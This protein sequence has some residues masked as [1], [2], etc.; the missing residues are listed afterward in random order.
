MSKKASK[1]CKCRCGNPGDVTA[2]SVDCAYVPVDG[3]KEAK[4]KF[5]KL[6]FGD[7]I[8][9]P[10]DNNELAVA[11]FCGVKGSCAVWTAK[12]IK[13]EAFIDACLDG[14][15]ETTSYL[16]CELTRTAYIKEQIASWK[17]NVKYA[18]DQKKKVEKG[19]AQ[20]QRELKRWEAKLKKEAKK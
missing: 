10:R 11:Y 6:K 1:K 8:Y 14:N 9:L 13:R 12:P 20:C 15:V 3:S 19:A 7:K 18:T 4:E 16:Y 17:R 5:K 2:C